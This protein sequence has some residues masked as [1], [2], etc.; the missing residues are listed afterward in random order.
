MSDMN[1]LRALCA[2]MK[3]LQAQKD[4]V[5]AK[6]T[7]L[8]KQLDELRLKQI[9]ELMEALEVKNATFEGLGRVQ[10]ASDLYCSTKPGQKDSAMQWLRDCGYADMISE[11][12]NATSMKALIRR[13]IVD[14][15]E[16]PEFLNVTP[17]IR[18]SIV[19]A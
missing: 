7:E 17:F 11:S 15:T 9:P 1:D 18:A 12:Y 6:S 8:T 10:L 14:G 19:K 2:K 13:L 3:E 4:D 16:V 5:D